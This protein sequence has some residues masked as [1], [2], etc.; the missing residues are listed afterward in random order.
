MYFI[1]IGQFAINLTVT[2]HCTKLLLQIARI[3]SERKDVGS[4]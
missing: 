4:N 3:E 2:L 1:L